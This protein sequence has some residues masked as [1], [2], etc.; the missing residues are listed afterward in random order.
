MLALLGPVTSYDVT[1]ALVLNMQ[2]R[3]LVSR[4]LSYHR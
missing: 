1:I 4:S 2:H 3:Q